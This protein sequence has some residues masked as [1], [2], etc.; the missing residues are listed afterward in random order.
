MTAGVNNSEADGPS[1]PLPDGLQDLES[2][3]EQEDLT[4]IIALDMEEFFSNQPESKFYGPDDDAEGPFSD[5]VLAEFQ[6]ECGLEVDAL[7]GSPTSQHDQQRVVARASRCQEDNP[8]HTPTQSPVASNRVTSTPTIN[9]TAVN[10]LPRSQ[11]TS[12]TRPRHFARQSSQLRN[13]LQPGLQSRVPSSAVAHSKFQQMAKS[14]PSLSRHER[15]SEVIGTSAG[16]YPSKTAN[17]F[18]HGPVRG[19]LDL[20]EQHRTSLSRH[21]GVSEIIG[22]SAGAYPSKTTNDFSHGPVL[23]PMIRPHA[24]AFQESNVR[25]PIIHHSTYPMNQFEHMNYVQSLQHSHHYVHPVYGGGP[26][27][28]SSL[29]GNITNMGFNTLPQ[30]LALPTSLPN[31]SSYGPSPDVMKLEALSPP[32]THARVKKEASNGKRK[33]KV[34]NPQIPYITSHQSYNEDEENVAKLVEAM[35]DISAPEDNPGMLQTWVKIRTNK[36][37]KVREKCVELLVCFLANNLKHRGVAEAT[38]TFAAHALKKY[39]KPRFRIY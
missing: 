22:T 19:L 6:A 5:A 38:N 27:H 8:T 25:S 13:E 3:L 36:A 30:S 37:K 24:Q 9:T 26:I 1:D 29:S 14:S 12:A 7:P 18:S 31:T 21:E 2:L 4:S 35:K 11:S 39:Q 28:G 34:I 33:S 20:Q 16:A 17:D 15:V 32:H 23:S 10:D